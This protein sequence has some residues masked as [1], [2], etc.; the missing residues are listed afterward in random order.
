MIVVFSPIWKTTFLTDG[1][2]LTASAQA[3]HELN[4]GITASDLGLGDG[5]IPENATRRV[6]LL[7]WARGVDVKDEDLDGDE[8]N[9][10][11]HMGDPMHTPP[12]LLNYKE[13]GGTKSTIFVATNEG[14]LHAIEHENGT[15]LFAFMPKELLPNINDFYQ[16][17]QSTKHPY[18]LDGD[19]TLW[20][21]DKNNNVTVDA[22]ETAHL[23]LGMRRGGNHYYA[24]DVS[25]R[26]N[27][28]LLWQVDGGSDD[29]EQLGQTWSKPTTTTISYNGQSKRVVIF[30]GGYD[31]NQ[32]PNTSNL[33]A[34]QTPDSI[35]NAIYIVDAE[36]GKKLWSG[37]GDTDGDVFFA[38]MDYSIPAD[39]RIIDVDGDG[40]AD[41]MYVG[42]MGGQLWRFDF[43]PYH[44]SGQLVYG[45]VMARLNGGSASEARRL[46]NEPD[47]ALVASKGQRFL[48][49]SFG[50]G[51]RAHPLNER[52][53]D[54]FY[55]IRSNSVYSRPEGYGKNTGSETSP[56]WEPLTENDL[57]NVTDELE[58]ELNDN[59]WLL[60]LEGSGEKVT[61][62]SVTINNQVVFTSYEPTASG[63]SCS[64]AIGGG[65]VY[66]V[67]VI[68]G[69][70]TLDL[71][72][73]DGA[74]TDTDDSDE[75]DDTDDSNTRT[76]YHNKTLTKED[77]KMG[78]QQDGIPPSP[79]ALIT[80]TDG[81]IG[82]TVLVSTEKIDVD[83]DNLTQRTYWQD[84]GRGRLS[85]A[86]ITAEADDQ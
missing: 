15:E 81:K 85:P 63:D 76:N 79:T 74:D 20:H 71:D 1:V 34:S 25:D 60:E 39:I 56:T 61:G 5:S 47:V 78:L 13:A 52:V 48:S 73:S 51:W 18:G 86:E 28:K 67:D 12:V 44:Q 49:V 2:D 70:P 57:V 9:V 80:E 30:A 33:T 38:D 19:L 35:G 82:T 7:K 4:T 17:Q 50:S 55:M 65:S 43:Q 40:L 69:A 16:N 21:D 58:P 32:D 68:S 83:F 59:G 3:L 10:R 41:Q 66:V 46:Y 23:F 29:F 27:P 84:N 22:G 54:R 75:T 62:K 64:P 14:L 6:E 72:G 45:G 37:Q 77:R 42:D 31:T 24:F 53:E 11:R 26:L 36:T 8:T